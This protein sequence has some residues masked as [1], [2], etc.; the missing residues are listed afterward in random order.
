MRNPF[1]VSVDQVDDKLQD[2]LIDLKSDS[3]CRDLFEDVSITEFW[4]QVFSS[5]PKISKNCLTKLMSFTTTWL[6][7]SA[8]SSPF[9]YKMEAAQQT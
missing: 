9:K 2:E 5:Y 8:F 7:E 6:C 1:R 4:I 3:G